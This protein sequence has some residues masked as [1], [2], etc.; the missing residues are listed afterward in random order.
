[1]TGGSVVGLSLGLGRRLP[2][3][4]R[5]VLAAIHDAV[6]VTIGAAIAH[7]VALML[8]ALGLTVLH[9][10][11]LPLAMLHLTMLLMVLVLLGRGLRGRR[12]L[13]GGGN[14]D[15]KRDRGDEYLHLEIS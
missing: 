2:R 15:D 13:R 10:A 14:R 4:L 9:L 11:M 1:M 8:A 5:H 7:G 3:A 6:A 12:C